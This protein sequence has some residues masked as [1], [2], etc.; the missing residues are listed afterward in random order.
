MNTFSNGFIITICIFFLLLIRLQ[1]NVQQISKNKEI[2]L[3]KMR[4]VKLL[5][6][7]TSDMEGTE[8]EYKVIASEISNIHKN[9]T[10]E[11]EIM[12]EQ[13]ESMEQPMLCT[14]A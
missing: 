1:L 12:A 4:K 13:E 14:I 11:E 9:N 10:L 7:I 6:Y 5:K 8:Q 2:Q 3:N